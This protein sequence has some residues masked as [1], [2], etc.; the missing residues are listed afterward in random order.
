MIG[1]SS[2]PDNERSVDSYRPYA[3]GQ[4]ARFQQLMAE[5]PLP[6]QERFGCYLIAGSS[7]YSDLARGIECAVFQQFFGNAP[8]V[9]RAEY[10][11]YEASSMFFLLVDREL[12]RP[13]GTLRVIAHS[14]HGLK[15]LTDIA[16][17]PLSIPL[18][19]VLEC[20]RIDR[21]E[22]CWDIGTIAVLKEYRGSA[23]EHVVS[24]MLCGLSTAQTRKADVDH[25]VA[26][27]D[28]HVFVQL[29]QMLAMPWV[30]I[31]GSRA[32]EYLG[33]PSSRAVYIH[34]P[35]IRASVEAQLARLD[36]SVLRVMRPCLQRI[37]GEGLPPVVEVP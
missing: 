25:V 28:Q 6:T 12:Q 15:T 18:A 31:A 33:S 37:L 2:G 13:A 19:R 8:S 20:H 30:P 11:A 17:E 21:L 35:Q 3:R 10:A 27:M 22:R 32:F 1:L 36:E 24:T 4:D 14:E 7:H 23:S 9:M 26:I 34:V 5:W 29:T 16:Q